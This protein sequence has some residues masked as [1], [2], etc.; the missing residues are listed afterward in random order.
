M[1]GLRNSFPIPIGHKYLLHHVEMEE[2]LHTTY[3]LSM[4][5]KD[6]LYLISIKHNL[7]KEW[8]FADGVYLSADGSCATTFMQDAPY[9]RRNYTISDMNTLIARIFPIILGAKGIQ[10]VHPTNFLTQYHW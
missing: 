6:E 1:M 8:Y 4:T 10:T 3:I 7:E 2:S 5:A 9:T